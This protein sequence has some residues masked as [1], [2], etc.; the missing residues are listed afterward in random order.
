MMQTVLV[1]ELKQIQPDISDDVL[2]HVM[3]SFSHILGERD[4]LVAKVAL[5]VSLI[6][7]A[8][9]ADESKDFLGNSWHDKY[10]NECTAAQ[11][12]AE[13]KAEAGRAG[14]IAGSY[15]WCD[16]HT[17]SEHKDDLIDDIKSDADQYAAKIR[18][19]EL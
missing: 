16:Y 5:L 12:L 3:A 13:I 17:G 1:T 19:G 2:K 4:A 18:K 11:C 7:E 9:E 8:A 15:L 10:Y 14:F 6:K